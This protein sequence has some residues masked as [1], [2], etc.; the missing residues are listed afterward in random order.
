MKIKTENKVIDVPAVWLDLRNPQ[1]PDTWTLKGINQVK[2]PFQ[3]EFFECQN[4]DE[5][6]RIISQMIVRGAPTIGAT[7]AYG[8]VLA[9]RDALS[10]CDSKETIFESIDEAATKLLNS[11]P[12]AVDLK[13]A[14]NTILSSL[15]DEDD[16]KGWTRRALKTAHAF[17]EQI[18]KD[19][20]NIGI[21]GEKLIKD[22]NKILTHCNAG[23]LAHVD[24]GSALSPILRAQQTGKRIFTWI[25]ETRP[26]FQG[27]KLTA[28]ELQQNDVPHAV[29]TDN[30]AA[31]LMQKGEID[32]VI[33]GADRVVKNGDVANKI[34]TYALSILAKEH[35]IPF[36]VAFPT[37]T[38]DST[39][40]TGKDI[41]IELRSPK[42]ITRVTGWDGKRITEVTITTA[43]EKAINYAFDVTPSRNI[44]GY[45][46]P[47]GVF[48]NFRDVLTKLKDQEGSLFQ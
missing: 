48:S 30:S 25:D 31:F 12:T 38:I 5:V 4:N 16:W 21:Q 1:N 40:E 15:K 36:Y 42:E 26:R 10:N 47:F 20:K 2:L 7:A 45:I 23:P 27:A 43:T 33:V 14:V 28:W 8:L 46:T 41:P 19:G 32:L 29:I 35:D 24:H 11:R 22:G 18:I 34:G 13:N 3:L 6:P 37:S 9:V 44:T 17:V 39:L